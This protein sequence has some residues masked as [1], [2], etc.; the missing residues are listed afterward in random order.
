MSPLYNL[1]SRFDII[2]VN[3]INNNGDS[4]FGATKIF[5]A[6]D[7]PHKLAPDQENSEYFKRLGNTA[8][9]QCGRCPSGGGEAPKNVFKM[10]NR[11]DSLNLLHNSTDSWWSLL[12]NYH[13]NSKKHLILLFF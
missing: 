4:S 10:K 3:I 5:H 9:S 8:L 11:W 6:F 7:I 12:S 2:P 13:N 1:L